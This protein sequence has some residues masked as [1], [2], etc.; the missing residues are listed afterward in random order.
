MVN[1]RARPPAAPPHRPLPATRMRK[2]HE[3]VE[4]RLGEPIGLVE[5]A[6]AAGLSPHQF[7]LNRRLDRARKLIADRGSTLSAIALAAGFSSQAH[8]TTSFRTP[9][10]RTPGWFVRYG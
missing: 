1:G 9:L 2:V 8:M 4:A 3:F 5:L 6:A 10:G 7:V